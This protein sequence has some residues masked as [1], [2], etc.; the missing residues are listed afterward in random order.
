MWKVN[1][2]LSFDSK[3]HANLHSSFDSKLHA[4]LHLTTK[5]LRDS[6]PHLGPGRNAAW[7]QGAVWK[8][9]A[10]RQRRNAV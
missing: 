5:M 4:N 10:V 8:R 7:Q 9:D 6:K 3:L 1:L 2:H